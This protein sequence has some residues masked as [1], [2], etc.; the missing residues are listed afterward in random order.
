[1]FAYI[2][3]YT[4]SGHGWFLHLKLIIADSINCSPLYFF[5]V[6]LIAKNWSYQQLKNPDD[7]TF[8]DNEKREV[9]ANI[10]GS[11]SL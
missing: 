8:V 2:V 9:I 11:S 1:M 3:F 4:V 10:S 6:K 5:G 7:G